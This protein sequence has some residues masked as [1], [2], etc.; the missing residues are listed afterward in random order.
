[1]I[2]HFLSKIFSP[3]FNGFD[4]HRKLIVKNQFNIEEWVNSNL[5]IVKISQWLTNNNKSMTISNKRKYN[6]VIKQVH[7]LLC[8]VI[9]GV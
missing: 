6:L 5:Y 1:M 8:K 4:R 9:S 3:D 2:N 7:L